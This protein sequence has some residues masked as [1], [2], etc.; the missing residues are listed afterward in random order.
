M[1][2]Y[3][4]DI[5]L[6]WA[7]IFKAEISLQH[8]SENK[9]GTALFYTPQLMTHVEIVVRLTLSCWLVPWISSFPKFQIIT[10]FKN[11]VHGFKK[12]HGRAFDDP[13]VHAE[14]PKLPYSLHK[15]A[16]G[17]T[18]IKVRLLFSSTHRLAR[19]RRLPQLGASS[20]PASPCA[21]LTLCCSL[22]GAL[23]GWGQSVHHWADHRDAAQQAEGD[24]WG[25]SEEAGGG[26]CHL[27]ERDKKKPKILRAVAS[28]HQSH[29]A[30]N[31]FV[32]PQVPG[33]FT[34]AE[35]RSVFDASQIAGLN[36]LRLIN[37]TTAGQIL[38]SRFSFATTLLTAQWNLIVRLMKWTL[39]FERTTNI[40]ASMRNFSHGSVFTLPYLSYL[41]LKTL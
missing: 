15:L 34:D 5:G 6:S 29:S 22:A 36:C 18:G 41:C 31:C 24:G 35:R 33:Y 28:V 1:W 27:C 13:F 17:N 9:I 40:K 2:W 19:R 8:Q 32:F 37:D 14:K 11:T 25:R 3:R 39:H 20:Q 10:N 16:N 21:G 23:L 26:L 30:Q 12:F 38:L 4:I 7:L